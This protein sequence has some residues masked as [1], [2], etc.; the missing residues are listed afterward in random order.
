MVPLQD[1]GVAKEQPKSTESYYTIS[2]KYELDNSPK[3][4]VAIDSSHDPISGDAHSHRLSQWKD[5]VKVSNNH[6]W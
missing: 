2:N 6:N 3:L 1:Y 4:A 5:D